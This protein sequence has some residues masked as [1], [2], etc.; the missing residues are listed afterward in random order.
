MKE[1]P[2]IIVGAGIAGL[3]TALAAAPRPVLLISRGHGPFDCASALAQGGIAAA[4]GAADSPAE[5]AADTLAAGAGSNDPQAVRQLTEG[6]LE[7]VRWLQAQ[8]IVFDQDTAGPKLAQE[9]GHRRPRIL[10]VAGDGSGRGIIAGLA[11][12][13]RA[14]EHIEWWTDS[15]CLG[16]R[17]RGGRVVGAWIRRHNLT[18]QQDCAALILASG[19]LVGR[20]SHSTHPAQ[21]DGA[22]LSLALQCGVR[23]RDLH[24]LQFHPTA[25]ARRNGLGPLP[26]IT[27]ALRGA[28]A[29]LRDH[30]GRSLMDGIHPQADL[31]PRD[32][33]ARRVHREILCG[34]PVWLHAEHLALSWP[35]RFPGVLSICREHG[36][37]PNCEPI[38]V[39]PAA[40]FHMG[41]IATDLLSRSSLAGLYAVGE[42]ACSGAHGAN[43]LASNALLE[44]LVFGLRLGRHLR[45]APSPGVGCAATLQAPADGD[46]YLQHS[47]GIE[48]DQPYRE[49]ASQALGPL[50]RRDQ[51]HAALLKTQQLL[52]QQDD[53]RGQLLAAMLRSGLADPISRGA[54]YWDTACLA[55]GGL[56][57]AQ[58]HR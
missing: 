11:A 48:F 57:N 45:Q 10:H 1:A 37:D 24:Y 40:H 4:V 16:W 46:A 42:V 43:R 41:G 25:L 7:G 35:T 51:L 5:H 53:W 50:R 6:A 32:I 44:G 30:R 36:I 14:S 54:H 17:L 56:R 15:E 28:G 47:D 38:P 20:F 12:A 23:V 9:G 21:S 26:L 22:L 3:C 27:E 31:A 19:S 8:G 58:T 49:I 55:D 33:V 18:L 39:C 13:A 52:R 29:R 2:L 34:R